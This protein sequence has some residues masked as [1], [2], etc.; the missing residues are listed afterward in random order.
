MKTIVVPVD[1][2][3]QSI[4]ALR[5]SIQ[6]ANKFGSTIH[7]VNGIDDAAA[8]SIYT[9]VRNM[10]KSVAQRKIDDLI[11]EEQHLLVN[12]AS[13]ESGLLRGETINA[14]CDYAAD[15]EASLIVM[16]TQGA[17]GLKEIFIGSVAQG[18][19]NTSKC[20][21]LVIPANT[22]VVAPVKIA[23]SLDD[24]ELSSKNVVQPV[25]DIVKAFGAKLEVFHYNKSFVT[26]DV[27]PQIDHY[28]DDVEFSFHEQYSDESDITKV[29][30]EFVKEE[31]IDILTMIRRKRSF[32]DKLFHSSVTSKEV[33][34]SKIPVLILKEKK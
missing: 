18:V 20:P 13:F 14:V 7:I 5:Y 2:S 22:K 27:D 32:W 12:G 17:S 25:K 4:E 15:S 34:H 23:L 11:E 33:F 30:D 24:Q 8:T 3:E 31:E 21:V 19:I 6:I 9:D 26:T 29:I 16:G 1:F 28:L 10:A